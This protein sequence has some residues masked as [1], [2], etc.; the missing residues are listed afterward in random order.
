MIE[1]NF[2]SKDLIEVEKTSLSREYFIIFFPG[3][4]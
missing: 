1:V 3:F 2:G 4:L